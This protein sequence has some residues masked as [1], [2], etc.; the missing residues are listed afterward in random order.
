M[1][2]VLCVASLLITRCTSRSS[3]D[4]GFDLVEELP[5]LGGAMLGVAPANDRA[6][7]DVEGGEQGR[8]AVAGVV[9]RAP[10]NLSRAHWQKRL[11]S[12]QRLDLRLLVHAQQAQSPL[13]RRQ[14][15][16]DDVVN[17]LDE[18]RI[19]G[20]LEVSVRWGCKPKARQI[21]WMA[22]GA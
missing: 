6:G 10:L 3:G 17:L 5:E 2:L 22:D 16:A 4:V 7:G 21:R 19:G 12:I 1:S 15:E 9:V 14:V 8:R 13:R 18:Q 11:A 20:Q